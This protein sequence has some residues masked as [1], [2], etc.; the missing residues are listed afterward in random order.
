MAVAKKITNDTMVQC[1]N[2]THGPLIYDSSRNTVSVEWGEFGEVQDLEYGELLIMRGTQP[3]FFRDNWIL[4][5]DADVLRKLGVERYY[6]NSLTSENFDE[7]F[8]W[9]PDKI[10]SEVPKMSDGMKD[11]IRIR[12]K[13]LLKDEKLDSRSI[14]KAFNEVFDCDLEEELM[15]EKKPE[16]TRKTVETVTIK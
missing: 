10:R 9:E 16:K 1:K 8:K 6:K 13:E 5:D 3:R 14:I 2:G 15:L 12:A 4:I 7:V 11:S